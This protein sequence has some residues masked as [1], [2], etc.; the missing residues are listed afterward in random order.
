M[1]SQNGWEVA[2]RRTIRT[3]TVP[4]TDQLLP[5]REG[6]AATVLLYV[7]ARFHREVEPLRTG[8]SWGYA[9]RNIRGSARSISNHASGTAIDLNAPAHPL[10]SAA[11]RTFTPAKIAAVRRIVRDCGG[12]VRWGGDYT[13]RADAMHFELVANEADVARF[14][15]DLRRPKTSTPAWY[16]RPLKVTRPL[17]T[18]IDVRAVQE[19]L[20]K[21]GWKGAADGVYG[22][23][24]AA[25]VMVVQTNHHVSADGI[26]GPVTAAVIG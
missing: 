12:A 20:R 7:A 5:L 15:V 3:Y 10:G 17:T 9:V 8:W 26:V 19:R 18:G 14:A 21:Y 25:R 11:S 24:T 16:R 22:P 6:D 13:G 23:A 2:T 1:Y 4:G